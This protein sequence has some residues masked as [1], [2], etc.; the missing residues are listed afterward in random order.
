MRLFGYDLFQRAD[1]S[2]T[3][4]LIASITANAGGTTTAFPNATASLEACSG[5]IGRAFASAEVD[6]TPTVKELLSP[7]FLA[8]IG[9]SLVR[10][11]ELVCYMSP[12]NGIDLLP[13]SSHDVSGGASPHSWRYR[14]VVSGPSRT[15]TYRGLP[16]EGVIHLTYSVD[17]ETPWKGA[18]PLQVARIAGRLSAETA[19]ALADESSGP[20]GSFLPLPVD[21][22]DATLAA[23]KGDIRKSR[24]NLLTVESGDWDNSGQGRGTDYNAQRFG[25]N[26]PAG[27]VETMSVA[28]REVM[29]ACGVN[30]SLFSAEGGSA[31]R[32]AYR[33]LLF[34]T[35]APLGKM[36]EAELTEKLE[37]P[38]KLDW[39]ELRASDIA[40]RARAF[41]SLVGGG[42][43]VS[44]ASALSGLLMPE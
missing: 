29:A 39:S 9:R 27:L 6:A 15:R 4:A 25:S 14:C 11:G 19:T 30:P 41:Q 35:V 21:G 18:G 26:P 3:D 33:Q 40:G 16:R 22:N 2:Y 17:P 43:D 5:I 20:R 8:L 24:G 34:G 32:E 44:K 13:C 1:S 37:T 36:V 7:A 28:S 31:G 42:M 12:D 10:R 38:V 23:L